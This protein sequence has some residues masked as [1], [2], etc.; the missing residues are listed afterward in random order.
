MDTLWTAVIGA[1]GTIAAALVT[2]L[3]GRETSVRNRSYDKVTGSISDPGPNEAVP[4]TFTCSGVVTGLQSGLGLW[5]AIEVGD[6]V[7]PREGKVVPDPDN[8]WS[9]PVFHDPVVQDGAIDRFAV[10]LFVADSKVDR[11]IGKWLE[12][13]RSTGLYAGLRGL[14]G[15]R[16]IARVDGLHL[17]SGTP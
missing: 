11:R 12:A 13:G 15:A 17:N 1:G 9:A 6:L 7:W 10:S 2:R 14:P 8:K 16:R 3:F 4:R 5:L